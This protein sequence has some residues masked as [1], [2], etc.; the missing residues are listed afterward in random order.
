M[1][2]LSAVDE[3]NTF[4]A[5]QKHGKQ[6]TVHR[7]VHAPKC[8]SVREVCNRYVTYTKQFDARKNMKYVRVSTGDTWDRPMEG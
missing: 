7:F 4:N 1:M 2:I 3:T 5:K 6:F 8:V